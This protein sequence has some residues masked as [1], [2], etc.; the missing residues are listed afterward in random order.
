MAWLRFRSIRGQLTAGF[1]VLELLF[2]LLFALLV[3][4]AQLEDIHDRDASRIRFQSDLL[5]V[6]AGHALAHR[7]FERLHELMDVLR[8]S[9]TV[10]QA[11][12]TDPTGRPL[13]STG[14]GLQ[15]LT[16]LQNAYVHPIPRSI[17][18]SGEHGVSESVSP[19]YDGGRLV[20]YAFI[21][22]N[23]H[24]V[25]EEVHTLVRTTVLFGLVG[26]LGAIFAS[27]WLARSITGPLRTVMGVTRRLIRDPESKEGFPLV[28]H[29]QNEVGE[30]ASA[31]N[32][33]VI[34]MEEQRGGLSD[35]LALLDSM[36]ANAPVG[37]A[38]F[39]RKFRYVRVNQFLATRSG[40]PV[41]QYLGRSVAEIFP[42]ESAAALEDRLSQVFATGLPAQDFE[43]HPEFP[44]STE[45]EG[46]APRSWLMNIY[47]VKTGQDFVRW[48]GAVVVDT[49]ERRRAEATLRRTEKLAV[50]GQLA[51]SIAHEINNPLEAVTNLLFLL[52]ENPSLD[53]QAV[54]WTEMAQHQLA[55]VSEIAQQTLRFYRQSTLPAMASVPELLDSVV[56]LHS[57]RAHG[58]RVEIDRRYGPGDTNLFCLSGGL[59]QI[60]ANLIGNALD[61]ML[62]GGRLHLRARRSRAWNSGPDGE[63][64]GVRVTIADTGIGMS[65]AVQQRIF[66][67]FFTT[68]EAT[69][70]GLGL[71]VTLEI[72]EKHRGTIRV[73]S[74][75][76]PG[77]PT[78]TVFMVFFPDAGI[79][80]NS[81]D[82]PVSAVASV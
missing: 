2:T 36:L 78:G 21:S 23:R 60:F 19:L 58:L 6:E 30:L 24:D 20:G 80:A 40:I 79:P 50:A 4:R 63:T 73:R 76:G 31:F 44:Q 33:M 47:P 48:V 68:K 51:A 17:F 42:P 64:T 55:R 26:A 49:T 15:G 10:A 74:R 14:N 11:I 75:S 9:P 34:S 72:V 70:T 38:F 65:S 41:A 25:Q 28:V 71:W 8:S 81:V 82:E 67:P 59:R 13:A 69:G 66:E 18:F 22:E 46:S 77:S 35:T 54:E 61:A 53:P 3:L 27:A 43:F 62:T 52:R 5:S 16:P 12:V 37:F 29:S 57:G 45:E 7:D 32:L 39:D 56:T 1:I